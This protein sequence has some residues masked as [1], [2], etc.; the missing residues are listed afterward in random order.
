VSNL[1]AQVEA[2]LDHLRVRAAEKTVRAYGSDLAQFV[3]LFGPDGAWTAE[4]C[5]QY[6]RTYG[7]TSVTRARKRASLRKF[8]RYVIASGWCD[9]DPTLEI[10]SPI[11][12]KRLPKA[13]SMEQTTDLLETPFDGKYAPRDAAMLELMYGA[14]LRVSELVSLERALLDL[15]RMCVQVRGKGNKDRVTFF[16]RSARDT[17]RRYLDSDVGPG[18][19]RWLFPG[20]GDRPLTTRTVQNVIKRWAASAGLPADV[21]PHTLRHSFATHLLDGGAD[22]KSVQQLLG[23]ESLATTQV[24]THISVERLKDAVET[25]HPRSHRDAAT[26]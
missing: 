3:N 9:T 11:R 23:H 14:G 22:L 5:R 12:R 6:L 15:D 1:A 26:S 18:R 2:F 24:Y 8:A 4:N 25:A 7:T 17:I 13:L 19:S 10:E 16:G 20:T 21:S